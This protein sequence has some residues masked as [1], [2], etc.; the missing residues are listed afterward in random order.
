MKRRDF[1]QVIAAL[2]VVCRAG[3]APTS[4]ERTL[5]LVYLKGGNDGFNSVVPYRDPRYYTMRP[6]L[7]VPRDAVLA[8]SDSHGLNPA[9]EPLMPAWNAGELALVQ[10]IGLPDIHQQHYG[11]YE[12]LVTGAGAGQYEASGWLTRA[13]DRNPAIARGNLDA[14]AF[15]SLDT[16]EHDGMGPFRGETRRVVQFPDPG[17]WLR[18]RRADACSHLATPGT[19]I[20]L[21][22]LALSAPDLK[23]AF[24]SDPFGQAAQAAAELIAARRA[25]P[26]LHLAI[27]GLDADQ[28]HACD[29]HIGQL[30]YH[31]AA[32]GRLAAGLAALR[33]ALIESG[34]WDD[35]MIATYDE[36]GR[37]PRENTEGGTH[38]GWANTQ[39]VLG[40]K[41]RGGFTGAAPA[42]V[43]VHQIGGPEAVIDYRELY[44]TL[45]EKWFGGSASSVFERRFRPLDLLRA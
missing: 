5:I 11:D 17:E 24:P 16:R 28:H 35:V 15:G 25:P 21:R 45:V 26:V 18:L 6:H 20:F 22:R 1:L 43:H 44:S 30:D 33:A 8:L 9:L 10:G 12:R 29:T 39:F 31:P 40:G 19:E 2:P 3:A 13:F 42:L 27:T 23:T 32:L 7:A 34:R 41:V 14:V 36:F 37:A 4:G 38:H